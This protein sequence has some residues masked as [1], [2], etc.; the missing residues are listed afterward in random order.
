MGDNEIKRITTLPH[1]DINSHANFPNGPQTTLGKMLAVDCK[2]LLPEKF[3][4]KVD[5]GTM[6]N[7]VEARVPLL[8]VELIQFAFTIPPQLKIKNGQEKY[9]LRKAV[10]GLL[11]REIVQRPK[12]GF[13]TTVGHWMRDDLREIVLQMIHEGPLLKNTLKK[14]ARLQ[15]L[16]N[17]NKK[18]RESPFEIWTL[19]AA[20]LWYDCY[21]KG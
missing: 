8:D 19:F 20:E 15:L 14:D 18:V 9:I 21:F 12:F 4:M 11:P 13:G 17:L 16:K 5:K 6:A 7:S 1:V 3:L 10:Q 2:N